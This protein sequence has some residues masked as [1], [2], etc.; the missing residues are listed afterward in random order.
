LIVGIVDHPR[1]GDPQQHLA[2]F[3]CILLAR[4]VTFIPAGRALRNGRVCAGRKHE[5]AEFVLTD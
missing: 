5:P 2:T 1:S 4:V 3:N